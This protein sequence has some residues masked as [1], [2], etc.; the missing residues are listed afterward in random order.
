MKITYKLLKSSAV[1]TIGGSVTYPLVVSWTGRL[2]V[3]DISA[4]DDNT[5]IGALCGQFDG[6]A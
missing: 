1:E 2:S 4:R 3:R 6:R 5:F